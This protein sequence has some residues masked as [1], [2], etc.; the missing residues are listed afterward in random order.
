[1]AIRCESDLALGMAATVFNGVEL[2]R[3]RRLAERESCT[4]CRSVVAERLQIPLD[5]L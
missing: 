5:R 3:V 2:D 1:M 4:A